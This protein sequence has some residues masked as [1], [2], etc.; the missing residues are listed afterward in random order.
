MRWTVDDARSKYS[1]AHWSDGYFDINKDGDLICRPNPDQPETEISLAAISKQIVEAGLSLPA[2]VRFSGI[3]RHRLAH[4]TECFDRAIASQ[5]FRGSY[6]P[7]YPI[8]VNQQSSV[9]DALLSEPG[10]RLGLE[11]GS[12]PELLAVLARSQPNGVVVCNG[13]KDREYIRIA[14]MGLILKLRVFLIVEKA[15]ELSL[16]I[17]EARKMGVRPLIGIRVRLGSIGHGKWQNTGGDTAKFGLTAGDVLNA[18]EELREADMMDCL[19]VMH[20]HMGSQLAN[21]HDIQAG[22]SE[23]ANYYAELR[24]LG[25]PVEVAN[26]GGGL[27]V[28]YEGTQSRSDCSI[29]YSVQDY[30]TTIVQ[31]FANVCR[32]RGVAH[33]ELLSESGR[34]LTAHHA[35]LVVNVVDVEAT[36]GENPIAPPTSGDSEFIQNIWRARES[37]DRRP[38]LEIYHELNY[39]LGR[40]HARFQEGK[41]QLAERARVEQY[42]FSTCHLLRDN[43][44]TSV[45][46]HRETIDELNEK[47]ADKYF[48]N[49]SLF[50]SMPDHWAID[51]VFPIVPLAGLTK[52][53]TRHAILQDIT[54]DSDGRVDTYVTQRAIEQTLPLHPVAEN[55]SYQLGVFMVGAYQEILGDIHNLFGNPHSIHV[56]IQSDGSVG[57]ESLRQGDTVESV[58]GAVHLDRDDLLN[59]YRS[60]FDAEPSLSDEQ[61][62]TYIAEIERGFEGYTYLTAS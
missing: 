14:I 10:Q 50:Q 1:L 8:K 29:N 15:S 62:S 56:E 55:E 35:V 48:C 42:Y 57:I 32:S 53:P 22:V 11:A 59:A 5:N 31:T 47:L 61:R 6:T 25:V 45:R 41:L 3:L 26:V 37:L 52:P 34:A 24:A 12:K 60:K 16:I 9:I 51:Q 43:L 39:E 58:L 54:C 49:Y 20:F 40:A 28:D 13:Y 4:L 44:A 19:K 33:P 18:V 27:G 30:A 2:L 36:P 7:V 17:D 21:L 38:P 23:A 46:A